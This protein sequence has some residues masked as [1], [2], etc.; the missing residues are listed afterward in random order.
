MCIAQSFAKILGVYGERIGACHFIV[1]NKDVAK[2]V[3]SNLKAAIR[4]N[5]SSPPLHG[6]RLA[7]M[8]LNNLDKRTA[9]LAELVMITDRIAKMRVE[10]KKALD[11]NECPG[12]WDHITNQIGMFSFTGLT[13]P[14]C[15]QMV[16]THHIYLTPNGR[17]SVSGLNMGNVK[18]TADCIKIVVS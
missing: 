3:L 2:A 16:N 5:W 14:Q 9:W 4:V 13:P 6:G 11:E 1:G 18:Y 15:E 17:I 10:L 7:A 8:I 12:N